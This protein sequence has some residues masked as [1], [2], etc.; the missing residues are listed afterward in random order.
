MNIQALEKINNAA[1]FS[2]Y[3]I[4]AI[5]PEDQID[6]NYL[7]NNYLTPF[8]TQLYNQSYFCKIL[9]NKYD[10]F[11][12]KLH[13][14]ARFYYTLPKMFTDFQAASKAEE[15]RFGII[16]EEDWM[17]LSK[18]IFCGDIVNLYE[19]KEISVNG[20]IFGNLHSYGN[21]LI[22]ENLFEQL[23]KLFGENK[24]K[25]LFNFNSWDDP[26][27]MN[28]Y[29]EAECNSGFNFSDIYQTEHE[30]D[31]IINKNKTKTDISKLKSPEHWEKLLN[32]CVEDFI[33]LNEKLSFDKIMEIRSEVLEKT[34]KE[35]QIHYFKNN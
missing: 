15:K 28:Y 10:E 1:V 9:G 14:F 2:E 12:P 8:P 31:A 29:K 27:N 6:E 13:S 33:L 25:E 26:E 22:Q 7:E 3:Q 18:M 17:G 24:I 35:L 20:R 34:V 4:K 30:L 21:Y 11:I 19:P 32:R 23:K 16:S 5:F